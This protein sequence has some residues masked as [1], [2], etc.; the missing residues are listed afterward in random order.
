MLKGRLLLLSMSLFAL[1]VLASCGGDDRSHGYDAPA[2]ETTPTVPDDSINAEFDLSVLMIGNSH[3]SL[4]NLPD[5]LENVI[6]KALPGQSVLVKRVTKYHYLAEHLDDPDTRAVFDEREW[7]YVILQAQ[8]YSISQSKEYP[9][10]AARQWVSMTAE[11]GGIAVMFPEW[12]LKGNPAEATYVH[13]I[14][15]TIASREPACVAP[16][17]LA[18]DRSLILRP[19]LSLHAADGNHAN[20]TGTFLTAMVLAETISGVPA[21]LIGK[22]DH[23]D[24]SDDVQMF[25]QAVA[26]YS[27]INHPPCEQL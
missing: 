6:S 21:E 10:I 15:T 11:Q 22:I 26:S 5:T 1:V 13:D 27:I 9:T 14:H 3:S 12:G 2:A 25:L 20:K 19:Q 24:L 23:Y 18:W 8:K 17:G 7:D 16:V 4:V